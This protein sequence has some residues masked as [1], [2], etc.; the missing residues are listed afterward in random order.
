MLKFWK[1]KAANDMLLGVKENYSW[2][3]PLVGDE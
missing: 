1:L 3:V 2:E